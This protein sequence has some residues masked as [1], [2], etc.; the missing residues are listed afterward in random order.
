MNL[1]K[2]FGAW[3]VLTYLLPLV[4]CFRSSHEFSTDDALTF[5]SFLLV[6]TVGCVILWS[7]R[8]NNGWKGLLAGLFLG[9]SLPVLGG[10][11]YTRIYPD[12]HNSLILFFALLTGGP[13]AIGGGI[14]GWLRVRS[15]RQSAAGFFDRP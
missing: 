6:P 1:L 2:S 12:F 11:I 5:L 13:S 4:M 9:F 8:L 15:G 14:A 10:F 3:A 7:L